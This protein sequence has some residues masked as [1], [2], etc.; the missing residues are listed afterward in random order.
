[1][2]I[3][4]KHIPNIL[5]IFRIILVFVFA[6]IYFG[7]NYEFSSQ[8]AFGV[9]IL[10]GLTDVVDGFLARKY[11][12]ISNAGK[13]LDPLA[14]K[15]MQCTALICL[16]ITGAIPIWYSTPFVLKEILMLAG[17]LFILK[18][19]KIVVVSN[20]VGKLAAFVFYAVIGSVMLWGQYLGVLWTNVICGVSLGLT[21]LALFNHMF[22][23]L[24]VPKESKET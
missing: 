24:S 21:V 8:I 18:D 13:I 23:Y 10:A 3:Q 11:N 14:D 9:F 20:I 2:K 12:W 15:M 7:L 1:M 19:R 6:F 16:T 22:Q 4:A 17:G 5:S